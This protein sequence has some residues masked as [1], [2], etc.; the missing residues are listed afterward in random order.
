MDNVPRVD[1]VRQKAQETAAIYKVADEL[2][3]RKKLFTIMERAP[4]SRLPDWIHNLDLERVPQVVLGRIFSFQ[5]AGGEF[6]MSL[7]KA[8]ELLGIGS[9]GNMQRALEKLLAEGYIVKKSNGLRTPA[10]YLV[11]EFA[12]MKAAKENG[13]DAPGLDEALAQL[14]KDRK[15]EFLEE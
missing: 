2:I 12:C 13:W 10:S 7:K 3:A 15:D 4:Y 5:C 11:D 1:E 6:R 8:A 14:E 9:R